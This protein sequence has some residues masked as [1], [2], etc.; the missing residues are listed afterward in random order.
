MPCSFALLPRPRST[1]CAQHHGPLEVTVSVRQIPLVTATYGTWVARPA[2]T[3]MLAAGGDGSQLAR[4]VR[5]ARGDDCFVGKPR[6]R[7]GSRVEE[8]RTLALPWKRD[9]L[10]LG[11]SADMQFL[12]SAVTV[13][14]CCTAL[15]SGPRVPI[16]CRCARVPL[17]TGCALWSSVA[18]IRIS[19][20]SMATPMPGRETTLLS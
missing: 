7:R 13:H 11:Q 15:S 2:S 18:G 1:A 3:T 20:Q 6:R 17:A 14:A 16:V 12:L 4:G 9:R 8:T 19:W 5:P 10:Q